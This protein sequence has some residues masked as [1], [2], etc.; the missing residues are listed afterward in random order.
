MIDKYS[1]RDVQ[2]SSLLSFKLFKLWLLMS[3]KCNQD[4][5]AHVRPGSQREHM[6][7]TRALTRYH[8]RL[9][10]CL[11]WG[12]A[13]CNNKGKDGAL[14]TRITWLSSTLKQH[15][16]LLWFKLRQPAIC[17]CCTGQV[18]KPRVTEY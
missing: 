4:E 17:D 10:E 5:C 6:A 18:L 9:T 11:L 16:K 13:C 8:H 2:V 3:L 1:Y 12:T 7:L 14:V 15:H